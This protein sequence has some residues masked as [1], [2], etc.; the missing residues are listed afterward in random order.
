MGNTEPE[1]EAQPSDSHQ[2]VAAVIA[3]RND[4]GTIASTVRACRAIPKVDLVV[5]VDDGSDDDTGA[6][7][8]MA[9]AAVVR[10][11]VPRGRSS[12][13]ETG[14]KVVAMR[15]RVDWP[16][17]H[18]LFLDPD[19]G[20]SAVESTPLV[21]AVMGGEA[22]C[23]IGVAM[24]TDEL[25]QRV[26]S[27]NAS[28]VLGRMTGFESMDPLS[29]NRCLTREALAKVMPFHVGSAVDLAM[30]VDLLQAGERV[31]DIACAFEHTPNPDKSRSARWKPGRSDSWMV[32]QTGRL[33]QLRSRMR[34]GN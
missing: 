9:G 10:H 30:T 20:D 17:R 28:R 1:V 22:D 27:R 7:A 25:G 33:K 12:A 11:S 32:L 6:V 19:L 15:D 4:R 34:P 2:S 26:L 5:V 18:I 24:E 21:E 23:A 31:I 3:A 16:P 29:T 13:L 14:V 8:R